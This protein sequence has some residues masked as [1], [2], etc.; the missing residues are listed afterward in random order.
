MFSECQGQLQG[1]SGMCMMC[2]TTDGVYLDHISWVGLAM[3][4]LLN[5]ETLA[6]LRKAFYMLLQILQQLVLQAQR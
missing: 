5:L 2:L 3:A 4:E 1:Q 6:I